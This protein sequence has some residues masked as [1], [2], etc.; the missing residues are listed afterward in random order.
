M[1]AYTFYI[2]CQLLNCRNLSLNF[3]YEIYKLE[4]NCWNF[5]CTFFSYTF[6]TFFFQ[7]IH[8]AFV[9]KLFDPLLSPRNHAIVA[10][11]KTNL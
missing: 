9:A 2:F 11:K 10:L 6:I 1:I 8:E 5:Q 4:G 7:G 3:K